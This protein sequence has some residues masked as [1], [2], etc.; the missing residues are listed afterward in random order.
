MGKIDKGIDFFRNNLE[1]KKAVYGI[2]LF[3]IF[4]LALW[5]R[6]IPVENMEYIQALDPYMIT[7]MSASIAE[8]GSLPAVDVLRYFPYFN[9]TYMINEG[10]VVIPALMFQ[11]ARQFGTD[12]LTWAQFYPALMG[13]LAVIPLYFVGKK[14]FD[15]KAGLFAAFFL[16]TSV[17]VMHR[18]SAGW[19]G[20]EPPAM[21]LMITSIYFFFKAWDENKWWPGIVSG[22]LLGISGTAWGGTRFLYMLYPITVIGFVALLPIVGSVFVAIFDGEMKKLEVDRVFKAFAPVALLGT[23]ITII[24]DGSANTLSFPNTYTYFHLAVLGFL[25]ARYFIEKFEL[26]SEDNVPYISHSLVL[27]GGLALLLSP[28]YSQT[29]ADTTSSVIRN[30]LQDSTGVIGGTVAEN[31]PST[32]DEVVVQLGASMSGETFPMLEN[33]ADYLS[34]WT[35]GLIGFGILSVFLICVFLRHYFD[36]EEVSKNIV[37][38]GVSIAVSA[39]SYITYYGL[40]G[41][42]ITGF[43]PAI[44]LT[45]I[46]TSAVFSYDSFT[47]KDFEQWKVVVLLFWL[48]FFILSIYISELLLIAVL[49]ALQ[50]VFLV[51]QGGEKISVEFEWS[52]LII[53]VWITSTI[54]G[55][56]RRS[57]LFIL[58]GAPV[59]LFAG[60]GVS[61][62]LDYVKSCNLW[63]TLSEKINNDVVV[64]A[65]TLGLT[66]IL[67]VA[68]VTVNVA[69]VNVRANQ[70]GGSPEQP[71]YEA[72][73][74]MREE[75][76]EGSV[77]LSWWDYGYWTQSI[78]ER[79]TIADGGNHGHYLNENV[80]ERVNYPIAE[81]LSS[82]EPENHTDWLEMYGADYIFLDSTMIGKYS[83]VSQIARRSNEDFHRM[84][85][86]NCKFDQNT[87]ACRT[88]QLED[89]TV[90]H[91]DMGG[92]MELL[93]PL[94][95]M[96]EE[97]QFTA[98]PIM[99]Y[100]G[101]TR[102]VA[103]V[104]SEQ[105]LINFEEG[106]STGGFN[107]AL[108]ETFQQNRPFGGCVSVHPY[109]GPSR[110]VMVP[111]AIMD[112][113]LVRLYLM[114]G[115]DI[116][117]VEKVFDNGYV[118]MWEIQ[119]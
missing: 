100:G 14:M 74:Y 92:E 8:S 72:F 105:G 106:G 24:L 58:T 89:N 76:P 1:P 17:A 25:T 85:E 87:G 96:E 57:R 99:R 59:A 27:I 3:A 36:L 48:L 107:E 69:A 65:L 18:S 6:F 12:F 94:D 64:P 91:Y 112:S 10:T 30:A 117:F 52:Y 13:A 5:V 103:N 61:K 55:A 108:T 44:V 22:V 11:V 42:G 97:L 73:E 115:E 109:Y 29:V 113:T 119:R 38:G 116:D 28:I 46:T 43:V 79:P 101:E 71:W 81:F 19:F 4:I 15:K 62:S 83:A 33:F 7:R 39:I 80:T 86:L 75:T 70:L 98:T 77:M 63:E 67:L 47:K 51:F 16:A 50:G 45:T 41:E 66:I 32:I 34:G 53:V 88:S 118:K 31:T 78:G 21:F 20:K 56:T 90:I 37:V 9:P 114:D 104:C 95:M 23:P 54:Y 84:Q 68:M 26:V 49:G 93:L 2:I 35:F 82:S 40:A 111:P 110:L 60:L 102:E